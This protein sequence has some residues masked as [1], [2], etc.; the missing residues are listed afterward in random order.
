MGC[1][2]TKFENMDRFNI[3]YSAIIIQYNWFVSPLYKRIMERKIN[4]LK[5]MSKLC[6]LKDKENIRFLRGV[7]VNYI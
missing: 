6:R 1:K 3:Y 2:I 4:L 5:K 7:A